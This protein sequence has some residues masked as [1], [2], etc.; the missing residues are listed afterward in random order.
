MEDL[1]E[2][3]PYCFSM[4]YVITIVYQLNHRKAGTVS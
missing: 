4:T 2:V 1:K 3:G